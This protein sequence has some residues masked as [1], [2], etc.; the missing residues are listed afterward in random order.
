MMTLRSGQKRAEAAKPRTNGSLP[1]QKAGPRR[2]MPIQ[3]LRM[4]EWPGT[5]SFGPAGAPRGQRIFVWALE[6]RLKRRLN[7]HRGRAADTDRR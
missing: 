3:S 1:A 6:A 5:C 2:R 7:D 4:T